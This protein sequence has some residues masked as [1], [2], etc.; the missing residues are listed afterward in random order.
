MIV[1]SK[2]KFQSVSSRF[3]KRRKITGGI[4]GLSIASVIL[5]TLLMV[6]SSV[7]TRAAAKTWDRGGGTNNW[8]N[9]TNWSPDGVPGISDTVTI[10]T[11]YTV[12]V[13]GDNRRASSLTIDSGASVTIS[14]NQFWVTT[15]TNNG[16]LTASGSPNYCTFST[17][18]NNS[19]INLNVNNP[20][21]S[22]PM[23]VSTLNNTG[24]I[25]VSGGNRLSINSS[26]NNSGTIHITANIL[27]Y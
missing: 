24:T 22:Y 7:P 13:D 19:T 26:A 9:P 27:E 25:N 11:G 14:G 10:G 5:I 6:L 20:S 2:Q 21:Y 17:L 12:V 3:D 23:F 16:T 18:N 4:L 8:S 15:V 1:L